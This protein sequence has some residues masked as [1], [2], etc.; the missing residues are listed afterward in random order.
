MSERLDVRLSEEEKK[1]LEELARQRGVSM[2]D[3][4]RTWIMRGD[5]VHVLA[6]QLHDLVKDFNK[7]HVSENRNTS[8]S[9]LCRSLGDRVQYIE[10]ETKR[11]PIRGWANLLCQAF[12]FM[13]SDVRDLRSKLDRF[14]RQKEPKE[15]NV[16]IEAILDFTQIV[17]SYHSIFVQGFIEILQNMDEDTKRLVGGWYNDEFRTRYNEI[18]PKYED[19]LKRAHRELGELS[20]QAMPRAKE[21]RPEQR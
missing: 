4:V 11:G 6:E 18:T 19:F 17:T 5:I 10:D 15:K 13:I 1:R 9:Y 12:Q 2:T 7:W 21:F 8:I 3:L 16:L 20:E 14:I